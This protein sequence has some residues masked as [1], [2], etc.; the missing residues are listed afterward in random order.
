LAVSRWTSP[1]GAIRHYGQIASCY[2][3][4][5]HTLATGSLRSA[6]LHGVFV[7]H[8]MIG[9]EGRKHHGDIL[10]EATKTN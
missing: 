6:S 5:T 10:K 1:L 9:G 4:G 8:P 3:F 2:A 7:L